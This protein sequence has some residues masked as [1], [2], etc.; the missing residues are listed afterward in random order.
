[1]P[2]I[3]RTEVLLGFLRQPNLRGN[4]TLENMK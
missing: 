4:L 3:F 1:M 2:N